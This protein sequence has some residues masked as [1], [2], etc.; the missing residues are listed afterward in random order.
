[1]NEQNCKLKKILNFL[2]DLADLRNSNLRRVKEAFENI[3]N[4]F[5]QTI[6][7]YEKPKAKNDSYSYY[8]KSTFKVI[9]KFPGSKEDFEQYI[10]SLIFKYEIIPSFEDFKEFHITFEYYLTKT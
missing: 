5:P 4:D 2:D 9:I 7:D 1:M 8:N 10:R 3:K 6:F